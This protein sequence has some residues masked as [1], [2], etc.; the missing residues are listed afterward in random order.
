MIERS[1]SAERINE[2]VNHPS[3]YPW[4]CGPLSGKLDLTDCIN[5]GRYI[6]LLGEHG[7]FLFWKVS[8]GIY[9]AHS[10]VLPEGRGSWAIWAAHKALRKMFDEHYAAEIMMAVPK[11]NIAVR[12]LVRILKAKFRGT[13][14]D[15]WWRDGRQIPADIYSLTKS[16]WETCQ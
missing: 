16:D 5:D 13:I 11:G 7:G 14:D 10:A 1:M 9:D 8:D 4:V 15:G 2:I 3:V 6:A 12:A